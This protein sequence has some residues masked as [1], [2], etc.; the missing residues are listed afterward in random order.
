[1]KKRNVVITSMFTFAVLSG[2]AFGGFYGVEPVN[3]KKEKV[4]IKK[5]EK[6]SDYRPEEIN[7]KIESS[8]EDALKT[9][10]IDDSQW[11]KIDYA[12][13]IHLTQTL[14]D[15]EKTSFYDAMLGAMEKHS[16]VGDMM[17]LMLVNDD[18][19]KVII[20]FQHDEGKGKTV[21]IELALKGN[22]KSLSANESSKEWTVESVEEK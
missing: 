5:E 20:L 19:S 3:A 17:P 1:M 12:D 21:K 8:W 11:T 14:S 2:V 10:E 22:A 18:K 15:E 6:M 9:Y 13:R 7:K 4:E 16:K